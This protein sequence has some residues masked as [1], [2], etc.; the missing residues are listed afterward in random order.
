M[1]DGPIQ[2]G[3]GQQPPP[4]KPHEHSLFSASGIMDRMKGASATVLKAGHDLTHSAT[5]HKATEQVVHTGHQVITSPTTQAIVK[6]AKQN[7]QEV[8]QQ[9]I[10]HVNGA[11]D[12]G[13]RHDGKGVLLNAAPVLEQVALGPAG[14]VKSVVIKTATDQATPAQRATLNKVAPFLTHDLSAK[15]IATTIVKREVLTPAAAPAS[16]DHHVAASQGTTA[17]FL[18]RLKKKITVAKAAD[19][20]PNH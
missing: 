20:Q 6:S 7:G 17:D 18:L 16:G 14:L 11:V 13:K 8:V 1:V 12:A 15:G 19:V 3:D 10:R 4:K 2:Q 9:D 5:V